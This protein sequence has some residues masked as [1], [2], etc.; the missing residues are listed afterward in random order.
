MRQPCGGLARLSTRPWGLTRKRGRMPYR[1]LKRLGSDPEFV[2]LVEI[3]Q[4]SR[5]GLYLRLQVEDECVW[6]RDLVTGLEV[7][8]LVPAGYLGRP[9]EVWWLVCFRPHRPNFATAS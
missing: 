5:M 1:L 8:C 7:S 9:D 4:G 3:M 2:R 6:L